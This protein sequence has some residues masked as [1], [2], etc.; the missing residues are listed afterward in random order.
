MPTPFMHLQVAERIRAHRQLKSAVAAQIDRALPAFYLGH[1]AADFQ[2]IADIPR[3][4][5]H[6]YHLPP[7]RETIAHERM[8]QSYP[9]LAQTKHMTVDH[10]VF[11][12]A[13][14]S[15][16]LL[17]Q[18][19]Y[20]DVLIPYF[21]EA[22]HWEADHRQRFLVHNTLLTYLDKLALESLPPDAGVTLAAARPHRWLPFA[23][24]G[25][26]IRWREM[27]VDQLQPGATIQTI[28]IYAERMR[29]QPAAF[30]A[31]LANPQWMQE[32]V[33]SKAP[34]EE[35]QAIITEGVTQSVALISDYLCEAS[36]ATET[37]NLLE[38]S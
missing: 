4:A 2:T 16:L 21:M 25:D 8:L 38:R 10:A 22:S 17:D 28:A 18:L 23:G 30:A 1:V 32:Q 9:Q 13:Y 14:R 3:E 11:V 34:L 37:T 27:L 15:H 31:N 33:F 7:A 19:W 6:F 29:L 20:W 26:L 35:V 24:D 12:A 36:N 5:T